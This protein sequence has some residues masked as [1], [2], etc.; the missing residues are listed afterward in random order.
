[1]A[2]LREEI[3]DLTEEKKLNEAELRKGWEE[4]KALFSGLGNLS[5]GEFFSKNA[6]YKGDEYYHI[7]KGNND[8]SYSWGKPQVCWIT[9]S[10]LFD[11]IRTYEDVSFGVRG[12][13]NEILNKIKKV[14]SSFDEFKKFCAEQQREA[15]KYYKKHAW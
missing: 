6:Y 1:M 14:A 4:F 15:R 8:A 9:I 7:K 13:P 10:R 11:V 2:T 12:T 3:I 5:L